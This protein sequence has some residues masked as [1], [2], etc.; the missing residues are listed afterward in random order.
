VRITLSTDGGL[1]F[2]VTL[3]AST[4]NDGSE[5]ITV[6]SGLSS[7]AARVKVEAIGNIFFDISDTDF[8]L[9]PGSPACPTVSNL[10][11]TNGQAGVLVMLT[12]TNFT[13]V[14]AVRFNNNL[15]ATFTLLSDAQ[16][17]VTVPTGATT[18]PL[19]LVKTGCGDSQTANFHHRRLH[20]RAQRNSAQRRR[21]GQYQQRRHHDRRNLWL[22]SGKPRA[23]G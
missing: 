10:N 12:G 7:A 9:T 21:R 15:N 20:L 17:R 8:V 2:P 18:G 6:P 4:P 13:G 16:I 1:T 23:S 11:P 22:D 19:T 5:T 3:F 14:T